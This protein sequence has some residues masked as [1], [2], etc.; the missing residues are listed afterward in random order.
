MTHHQRDLE[1]ELAAA[2]EETRQAFESRALVYAHLY[3]V[4]EEELGA[5]RATDLMKRAIY[6]RGLETAAKYR[7]ASLAGDLEEIG[8]LFMEGSACDGALFMPCVD[9]RAPEEGRI[10]LRMDTCP[11]KDAWIRSGRTPEQVDALCE[12][13]AAVDLGTFE[14]AELGIRFLDRQPCAEGSGRCLLEITMLERG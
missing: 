5:E 8:R 3:D 9:E 1:A 6:R 13:A 10:V 14:G 11:L 4:L 2:R 12:I 7:A